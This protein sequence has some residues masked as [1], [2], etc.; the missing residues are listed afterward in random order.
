MSDS[1]RDGSPK[2][3]EAPVVQQ[4]HQTQSLPFDQVVIS[5]GN[6]TRNLSPSEFFALP[7]AQRIQF[8]VQQKVVFYSQGSQ[9]DAKL[10]LGQMRK[11]RAQLH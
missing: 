8:V 7:L 11:I 5:E 6:V 3:N 10:A 1:S 2:E 4:V 9:I